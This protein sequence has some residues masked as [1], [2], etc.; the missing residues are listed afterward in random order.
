[1]STG[2]LTKIPTDYTEGSIIGSILKMGLPSMFGFIAQH[3]Y[4]MV[5]MF[6]VSRL[7]GNEP[8]VAAITFFNNLLWMLFAFNSLIGPGSLAIISR[9]YGEKAYDMAE[10]AIKETIILKILFGLTFGLVSWVFLP[11]VLYL[12]GAREQ[13]LEMGIMYGRI[14][15]T[16]IPIMYATY[17]IFT[18]LRSISNP[19]WAMSLM[20]LANFIN[21]ILDPLL[22][23]G[24]WGFPK[25]GIKGAAY[26]TVISIILIFVLGMILFNTRKVNVRLH[27]F[28]K[29]KVSIMSMWIIIK[30]GIPASIGEFSIS[31]AKLVLTPIVAGF[32]TAVV[33]AYGVGLQLFTFGMML[34]VGIGMGL[35][36]LIGHNL[37]AAKFKRAKT[38]ADKAIQFS[39]LLMSIYGLLTFFLGKYY[40]NL[41]FESQETI[42]VGAKML[43]I[44]AI[45]SPFFGIFIMLTQIHIGVGLNVPYMKIAFLHSWI[46]Q[47]ISA[48]IVTKLL[49]M[50]QN[51]VWWVTS[52]A[53]IISTYIFYLYYRKGHW[54]RYKV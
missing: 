4:A 7:P 39:I 41:F 23:F 24:Y 10:K 26:A 34:L 49:G 6:W 12:L 30:L 53:A 8:G 1:M 14:Y 45:A 32:G 52:F 40:F 42:A 36:S 28:S 54:L 3:I 44:W 38:T 15:L 13:S 48:L 31:S 22:I 37:G 16:A 27:I 29:T 18:A 33:A 47:V 43:K 17:S 5:D 46:L 51:G 20:L 19:K 9:R 21:I 50:D 11:E 25:L 35:S 2:T